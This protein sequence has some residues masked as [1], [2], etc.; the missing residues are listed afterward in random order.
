MDVD[1]EQVTKEEVNN[2]KKEEEDEG[3]G[4]ALVDNTNEDDDDDDDDFDGVE[5]EDDEED[6]DDDDDN[7]D[8]VFEEE[9]E[10]DLEE[11]PGPSTED[12]VKKRKLE[13]TAD[14]IAGLSGDE[15]DPGNIIQG[16]RGARRGRYAK[17]AGGSGAGAKYS[18][19]AEMASD[20]D[21]W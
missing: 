7:D 6:E 1:G 11:G 12:V 8:E 20:E 3:K 5:F 2:E 14:I 17:S 19:K 18:A 13:D 21:S 15:V 10:E 16:G 9:E 4:A